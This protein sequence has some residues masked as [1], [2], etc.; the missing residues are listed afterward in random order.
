MVLYHAPA[1]LLTIV[2]PL[3]RRL[4]EPLRS[5]FTAE[6]MRALLSRHGFTVVHD[7][8]IRAIG[9]AMSREVRTSTRAINHMRIA[10]ADRV[11]S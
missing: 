2:G 3:V 11:T 6:Q 1:L 5:V 9:A 8:D 7:E 4:G 10:T